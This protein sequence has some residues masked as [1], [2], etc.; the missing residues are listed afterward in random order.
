M[1]RN[2]AQWDYEARFR[3]ICSCHFALIL[4]Y[5][6]GYTYHMK[7]SLSLLLFSFTSMYIYIVTS[8]TL[9]FLTWN[10]ITIPDSRLFIHNETVFQDRLCL[11]G[12]LYERWIDYSLGMPIGKNAADFSGENGL[13]ILL[14]KHAHTI[15][16]WYIN[17]HLVDFYDKCIGKYTIAWMV[18]DVFID[19]KTT[20]WNKN[21]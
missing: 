4:S 16:V 20:G 11:L 18:W 6:P 1:L 5:H 21:E 19:K 13:Q 14:V 12:R 10:S 7:H 17:L 8:T 15:H 9:I 2:W 3:D